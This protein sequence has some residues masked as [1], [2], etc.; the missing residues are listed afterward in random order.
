MAAHMGDLT[1]CFYSGSDKPLKRGTI[2]RNVQDALEEMGVRC[3]FTDDE[4]EP[5]AYVFEKCWSRTRYDKP[6]VIHAENLIGEDA[7]RTHVYDRGDAIVFNSE[8]LRW[9]YFNTY[10]TELPRAHVIPTGHRAHA[11]LNRTAADPLDEAHVMCISKWWKR[12]YKRFP[13]IAK[14]FDH[15]NRELGYERA[16][17]HVLGWLTDR[18]MPFVDARPR[19]WQLDRSVRSNPNIRYHQKGFQDETFDDVLA[20]THVVVHVSVIDSGPQ[21]VAEALSQGVP[22]VISNNMGAAEWV[23]ALGPRAGRV[24][25]L[26]PLTLDYES[27]SRLPLHSRRLCSDT[28]PYRALAGALKDILDDY[29][30]HTF[31]PPE[32]LTMEGIARHW[33]AV[34]REVVESP[35]ALSRRSAG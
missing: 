5:D 17:L 26:D 27:I 31:E 4:V 30:F 13:L 28:R 32:H 12:P 15:L 25:E 33:L 11:T 2:L 35:L 34:I 16:T 9:V 14:A 19:L 1:V 18:P 20:K 23:R 29:D 24:L 3:T 8:W 10:G 6:V 7:F 21:V 22:V